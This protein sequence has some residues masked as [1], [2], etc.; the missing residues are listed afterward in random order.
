MF[1]MQTADSSSIVFCCCCT[2]H[3]SSTVVVASAI[4]QLI[5]I[6]FAIRQFAENEL[7]RWSHKNMPWNKGNL[8]S[9]STSFY[10][11]STIPDVLCLLPSTSQYMYSSLSI[12]KSWAASKL[13]P[14]AIGVGLPY[15]HP[16]APSRFLTTPKLEYVFL[17]PPRHGD[18]CGHRDDLE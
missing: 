5:I 18:L 10:V 15:P 3:G 16:P 12:L 7:Q 2:K 9:M 17:Y 4:L 14:H 13:Y 8:P 6:M 1:L 11:L